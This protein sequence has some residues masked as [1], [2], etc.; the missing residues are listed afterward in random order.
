M[1][2]V[3]SYRPHRGSWRY[4]DRLERKIRYASKLRQHRCCGQRNGSCGFC[5]TLEPLTETEKEKETEDAHTHR[6]TGITRIRKI[7]PC[8]AHRESARY[9]PHRRGSRTTRLRRQTVPTT[10]RIARAP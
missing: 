9:S 8:G 3:A 6:L 2:H 1:G 5:E 4:R 10:G 7:D